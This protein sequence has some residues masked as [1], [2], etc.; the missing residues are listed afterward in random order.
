MNKIIQEAI[1]LNSRGLSVIPVAK[2]KKPLVDWKEFQTRLSTENDILEWAEKFPQMNIGVVTGKISGITVVDV[3]KGGDISKFPKTFTVKTGGGGWHLYYKYYP[4]Q[5]KTRIFPL[6]DV[7][8]D[9]GYVVAPP[10]IHQSGSLYEII[11]KSP[12]QPFPHEMFGDKIEIKESWKNKV[13]TPIEVGNRNSDFTSVIGGLL[14]RLPQHDWDSVAW[15]LIESK[16]KDQKSPLPEH[17]L[18]SIFESIAKREILK[19]NTGGEIKD[20]HTEIGDDE[21][22]IK[23]SLIESTVCF[24]A[25]NI[26]NNLLEAKIVTWI[27]KN[28]GLSHEIPYNLRINSDS[29]KDGLASLLKKTFDKKN[30]NETYPW[31]ILVAKLCSELEKIIRDHRQDFL[32]TETVSKDVTWM[33]EPFIQED[34]INT[35][36]G[37]GSSGKTMISL[38]LSTKL[39]ENGIVSMLIDYENDIFSW[40]SKIE[41]MTNCLDNFVYYDSEQIPIADQVD[42]IKEVIKKRNVKLLIVDSA[43][44][45]SGDS[46][47]DEK[48]A[49]RLISALKLFRTTVVL[50]AHQ[51]KNDGD[52]TPI[53][54]IQYENQARNVWNFKNAADDNEDS[55]LHIACK[56]TKANNTF[57]RKIPVG[58]RICFKD[59]KIEIDNEDAVKYFGDKFPVIERI[60]DL[61]SNNYEMDYKEIASFLDITKENAKTTLSRGKVKG[62]FEQKGDGRWSLKKE[63]QLQPVTGYKGV[64]DW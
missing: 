64:T 21:A 16:N 44:L 56:H 9:G 15:S 20:I 35:F 13:L 55:T 57:V 40:K 30:E 23:I 11:D 37:L 52:R 38:Y 28:S 59:N 53:G 41:K 27:E 22:L 24:K 48:A 14:T 1:R 12:M 36:F 19:R 5:N 58:F 43:S 10:S 18:K 8:G 32:A 47:T 31:T 2:D 34:Q 4:F 45:A 6:T 63:S 17:E 49:L 42:K 39:A 29:N 50:I 62:F 51:R 7:R 3:E 61:L 60:K 46:T 33:F 25:K 26:V 54:S